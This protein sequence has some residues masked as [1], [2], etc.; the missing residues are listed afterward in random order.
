[1][2]IDE[3]LAAARRRLA[4][5]TVDDALEAMCAG[6]VIVDIRSEVHRARDGLIPR[7]IFHPRNVLEWRCDPSSGYDDP[8][9]SGDLGRRIVLVCNEG[10]QSSLAAV[11]LQEL[12]FTL[13]TDLV[14]GFLAWAAAGLP[15]VSEVTRSRHD[16]PRRTVSAAG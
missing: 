16:S 13:A 12:G 14:G 9:L 7:A 10:Y 3:L 1:M 6:A 11:T 15:V 4:R 2:T 8:R 5:L